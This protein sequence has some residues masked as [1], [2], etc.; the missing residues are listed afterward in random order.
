MGPEACGSTG[1][2][3]DAR[4]FQRNC[5]FDYMDKEIQ[6]LYRGKIYTVQMNF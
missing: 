1:N 6:C 3:E 2:K 5:E 4:H